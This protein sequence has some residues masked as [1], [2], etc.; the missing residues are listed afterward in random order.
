MGDREDTGQQQQQRNP[1]TDAPLQGA[2]AP[3]APNPD[4]PHANGNRRQPY[5]EPQTSDVWFKNP[6][7]HMVWITVLLFAVGVY[8][9]WVFHRQFEEMQTQTRILNTQAEQSALDSVES[10]KKIERQLSIADRQATSSEKNVKAIQRQ[11]RDQQRPWLRIEGGISIKK[12][13]PVGGRIQWTVTTKIWNY[14][15]SPATRVAVSFGPGPQNGDFRTNGAWKV[16]ATCKNSDSQFD[17]PKMSIGVAFPHTEFPQTYWRPYST[18][19]V[20]ENSY[21]AVVCITYTDST[22]RIYHTRLLYSPDFN[23]F[24]MVDSEIR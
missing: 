8:T 6:D 16:S 5:A 2:A 14:G 7:W 13:S 21:F 20:P 17:N 24:D 19:N 23:E 22:K 15:L 11:F 9:A 18:F 3:T 10:A 1:Q 12:Q 4:Q